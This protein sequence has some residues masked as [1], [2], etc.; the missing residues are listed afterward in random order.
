[1]PRIAQHGFGRMPMVITVPAAAL[2]GTGAYNIVTALGLGFRFRLEAAFY[3][4]TVAH[5]GAGGTR[6]IAIKRG[7]TT[8]ASVNPTTAGDATVGHKQEATY[9]VAADAREFGDDDTLSVATSSGGTTITAGQGELVLV[10]RQ[11]NQ[12][13]F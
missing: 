8:L 11:L 13:A 3:V 9:A 4:A 2:A 7:S 1:M 5:A 6:T 12:A 10:L